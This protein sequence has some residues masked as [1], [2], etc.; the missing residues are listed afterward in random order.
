MDPI[1]AAI[2]AA[3]AAGVTGGVTSVGKETIVDAYQGIKKFLKAKFGEENKITKAIGE[4][5]ANPESKG[6]QLVLAENMAA[7][8]ASNEPELL[9]LAQDLIKAL[10][11]TESGRK[12]VARFQVDAR[13]AKVGVI[14][15]QAHIEGGIHFGERKE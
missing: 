11:E 6:Q 12:A 5:E 3:I 2:V 10:Q 14:G 4:V 1:T 13:G 8:A 7:Q 9:K 15:D